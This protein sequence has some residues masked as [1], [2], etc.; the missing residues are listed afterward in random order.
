MLCRP[1]SLR[2][3]YCAGEEFPI[4]LSSEPSPIDR[5]PLHDRIEAAEIDGAD[6]YE[7]SVDKDG[8]PSELHAHNDVRQTPDDEEAVLQQLQPSAGAGISIHNQVPAVPQVARDIDALGQALGGR[9][10]GNVGVQLPVEGIPANIKRCQEDKASGTEY[11]VSEP[12]ETTKTDKNCPNEPK[13]VTR[14]LLNTDYTHEQITSQARAVGGADLLQTTCAQMLN[15]AKNQGGLESVLL[16]ACQHGAVRMVNELLEAG[17]NVQSLVKYANSSTLGLTAIHIAV[18]HKQHQ[19][20]WPL[21]HATENEDPI[22]TTLLLEH[23][24]NPEYCDKHGMQALHVACQTGPMEVVRLL[25]DAGAYMEAADENGRHPL[26]YLTKHV[27]VPQFAAFL[28]AFG[29]N[30]HA[31]TVQG[32]TSVQLACMTGNGRVL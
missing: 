26:H 12:S 5:M 1:V 24:A 29:C 10:S 18:M 2:P 8:L 27:D 6:T 11:I 28:I 3:S 9:I 20:P 30:L 13:V 19:Q 4:M 7:M 32:L 14:D 16:Y 17:V 23:G 25:L 21:H 31:K 22:M 15:A